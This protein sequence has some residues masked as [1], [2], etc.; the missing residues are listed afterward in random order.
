MQ[1]K[2]VQ[3]IILNTAIINLEH[4][5]DWKKLSQNLPKITLN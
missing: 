1:L 4:N 2:K 5:Q 3:L